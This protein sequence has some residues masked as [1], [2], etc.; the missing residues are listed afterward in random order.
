[1]R[2]QRGNILFLILLAVILFAALSYAVTNATRGG[3]KSASAEKAQLDAA[4]TEQCISMV[5]NSAMR[6]KI[7]KSC[8]DET[9]SYELPGGGNE[10]PDNPSDTNCFVFHPNGA[11]ASPCGTY[12]VVIPRITTIGD[13]TT[14]VQVADELWLKCGSWA[15][16]IGNPNACIPSFSSDGTSFVVANDVC[17]YDSNRLN[18]LTIAFCAAACQGS[19]LNAAMGSGSGNCSYSL[20]ADLSLTPFSGTW[21]RTKGVWC[22]CWN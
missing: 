18:D 14:V 3:G 1:M 20:E 2:N 6:L 4:V 21:S 8:T 12:A 17:I 11:G 15:T 13:T 16:V 7:T 5:E 9:I 10:N 19:T 22:D